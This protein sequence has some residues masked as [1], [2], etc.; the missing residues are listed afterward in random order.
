MDWLFE[1]PELLD[2]DTDAID[3]AVRGF[4][5]WAGGVLDAIT[6]G[7][8][9]LVNGIDWLLSH[10]PWPL[11]V[12]LVVVLGWKAGA[13]CAAAC[14]TGRSSPWWGRWATGR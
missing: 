13:A 5:V 12:L 1:F 11:L 3:S 8:G 6:D 9:G 10:V 14:S 4:A 7:L 2:I